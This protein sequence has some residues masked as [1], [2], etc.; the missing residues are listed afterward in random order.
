[1]S[2]LDTVEAVEAAIERGDLDAAVDAVAEAAEDLA[3]EPDPSLGARLAWAAATISLARRDGP[4]FAANALDAVE[5]G[6]TVGPALGGD[7]AALAG[8]VADW[9]GALG[10]DA[11]GPVRLEAVTA[12]GRLEDLGSRRAVVL[13]GADD[14]T[15][16][17]MARRLGSGLGALLWLDGTAATSADA[18]VALMVASYRG[19]VIV[20]D[21]GGAPWLDLVARNDIPVIVLSTTLDAGRACAI[22]RRGRGDLL[23]QPISAAR[24]APTFPIPLAPPLEQLV[25]DGWDGVPLQGRTSP[26]RCAALIGD[27]A[28]VRQT[29]HDVAERAGAILF[30]IDIGSDGLAAARDAIA[31]DA[32]VVL[33]E[34]SSTVVDPIGV[35][36]L[37][38]LVRSSRSLV[39]LGERQAA[40]IPPALAAI[41]QMVVAAGAAR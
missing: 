3:D 39:L 15:R 37:A 19:A 12:S 29:A 24:S 8:Y 31:A 38:G 20:V 4:G 7:L 6:D 30:A 10:G 36:A 33:V 16:R 11:R 25:I 40:A 1:M 21:G 27:E 5:L 32:G 13:S 22:L 34:R 26:G 23:A 41:C 9:I 18:R 14:A 17:A 35:A 2:L 28:T